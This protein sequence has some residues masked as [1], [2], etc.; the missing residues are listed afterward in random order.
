M[1]TRRSAKRWLAAIGFVGCLSLGLSAAA[2][3][4]CGFAYS[5]CVPIWNAC[6]AET[7]DWIGCHEM[8]DQCILANG[9]STLP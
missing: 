7:G 8:L 5:F 9:C 3:D 2:D 6:L 4:A 1:I